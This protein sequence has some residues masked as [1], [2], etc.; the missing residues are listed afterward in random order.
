M[1]RL[2]N[3]HSSSK[4]M[5]KTMQCERICDIKWVCYYD[6]HHFDMFIIIIHYHTLGHA[7]ACCCEPKK[8]RHK[9]RGRMVLVGR[10]AGALSLHGLREQHNQAL[11]QLCSLK[12][13]LKLSIMHTQH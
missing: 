7:T 9:K 2:L 3:M 6:A 13:V 4:T 11:T 10:P 12:V 8:D 5:Y 1:N